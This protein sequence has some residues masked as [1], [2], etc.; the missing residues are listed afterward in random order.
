MPRKRKSAK[1]K[2][3]KRKPAKRKPAKDQPEKD[4]PGERKPRTCPPLDETDS[5]ILIMW[6]LGATVY[7]IAWAM[8][9]TVAEAQNRLDEIH[10]TIGTDDRQE[11][12][13]WAREYCN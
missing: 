6:I 3:A 5:I 8:N 7:E 12:A 10:A 2:S 11:A 1:R 9:M 4:Q 13:R